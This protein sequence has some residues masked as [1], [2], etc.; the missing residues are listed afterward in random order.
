MILSVLCKMM[1]Y[2]RIYLYWNE[3]NAVDYNIK[4]NI[5]D[6]RL[7]ESKCLQQASPTRNLKPKHENVNDIHTRITL[8]V[9]ATGNCLI[10]NHQEEGWSR[11]TKVDLC[12]SFS[13]A[14]FQTSLIH[15]LTAISCRYNH[16]PMSSVIHLV[17]QTTEIHFAV[18]Q[19][20]RYTLFNSSCTMQML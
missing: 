3:Q 14:C 13:L 7:I 4:F 12:F 17:L 1:W 6:K 2:C 19:N 8:R 9:K 20:K 15:V 10:S 5:R 11:Q 16:S 18:E